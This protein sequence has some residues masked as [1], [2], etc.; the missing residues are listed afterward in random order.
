MRR[1]PGRIA[2]AVFRLPLNAYAHD[3]GWLMGHTF[4]RFT[5]VGRR[6][7]QPYDTV[8]MVLH[9]DRAAK[10]AVICAGWGADTDWV[11]NLRA[12]PAVNVRVGRA[13]FRP[14]HRFLS[15]EEALDVVTQFRREHPYRVRLFETVLGWGNLRDDDVVRDFVRTH[16]FVGFRPAPAASPDVR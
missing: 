3:A 15:D 14:E 1:R 7:G 9:I 5:H 6:T 16:P 4:L 13:S 12:G 11:R 2:L 10:E 8:A